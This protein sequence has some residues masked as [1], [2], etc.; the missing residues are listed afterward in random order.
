ML[1]QKTS[2]DQLQLVV[3][4]SH[5]CT[6]LT[7]LKVHANIPFPPEII[8]A[9]KRSSSSNQG[10]SAILVSGAASGGSN[11]AA[12]PIAVACSGPAQPLRPSVDE[13]AADDELITMMNKCWSD[14]PLDRP[15]FQA[16]KVAIRKLNK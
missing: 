1:S 11:N 15:D 4:H 14:D 3:T 5:S 6:F 8:E 10:P 13:G 7:A 12:G 9:V 2:Y 16:L